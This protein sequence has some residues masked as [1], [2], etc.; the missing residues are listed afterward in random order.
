MHMKYVIDDVTHRKDGKHLWRHMSVT[1]RGLLYLLAVKCG[2]EN[3]RDP[4]PMTAIPNA[5]TWKK[6]GL[7]SNLKVE[8]KYRQQEC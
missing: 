6:I 7:C 3:I 5:M 4:V 1:V 2:S 8:W